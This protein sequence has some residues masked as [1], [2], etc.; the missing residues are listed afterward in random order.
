MTTCKTGLADFTVGYV[1]YRPF[2]FLGLGSTSSGED[3]LCGSMAWQRFGDDNL[4]TGSWENLSHTC[5]CAWICL[6][7]MAVHKR[8]YD[9]FNLTSFFLTGLLPETCSSWSVHTGSLTAAR[10]WYRCDSEMWTYPAYEQ[11]SPR[12]PGPVS[13]GA[14]VSVFL[15]ELGG[16]TSSHCVPVQPRQTAKNSDSTQAV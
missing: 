10:M 13:A 5:H 15:P 11:R 16:E 12:L 6:S 2:D 3:M 7:H 9:I 8:V 14:P 1:N 4:V